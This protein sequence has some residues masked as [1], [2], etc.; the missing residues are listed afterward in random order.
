MNL[1]NDESKSGVWRQSHNRRDD[2]CGMRRVVRI[3]PQGDIDRGVLAVHTI[4]PCQDGPAC[5]EGVVTHFA[6]LQ[7]QDVAVRPPR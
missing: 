6:L 1:Q 7:R 2:A 3:E 4:V 5:L